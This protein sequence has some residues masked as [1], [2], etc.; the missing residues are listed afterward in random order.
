M[1]TTVLV[2]GATGT[3]GSRVA[4]GLRERG[5][6]PRVVSRSRPGTD[7]FDWHDRA[8]WCPALDGMQRLYLVPPTD[9]SDPALVVGPFLTVAADAGLQRVVLL[10]SS[11]LESSSS[12][13]GALPGLV[14]DAVPQWAVLQPSWFMTNILGPTPLAAA[15][16][17]GEVV[18][19]TGEGRVAF[20]DPDDIAAVAVQAL[21][22]EPSLNTDLVLTGPSAHSYTELCALVA[23]R[24]GHPIRHR[25]VSAQEYTD[26]L[27]GAGVPAAYA[28][29]LASLDGPISRGSEDRVT[30][31]IQRLTGRPPGTLREFVAAHTGERS[32]E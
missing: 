6:V 25:S 2:L 23:A 31:T 11:A 4:Q 17:A 1:S 14:R 22:V 12:G 3:T 15:L 21:L 29:F 32:A 26:H 16:A 30:D 13:P 18:T 19:A 27:V 7:R 28:P 10:S 8:T 20:V 5:I 24:R 9:G